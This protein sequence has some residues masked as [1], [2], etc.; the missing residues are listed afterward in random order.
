MAKEEGLLKRIVHKWQKA[1][2]RRPS[3][4]KNSFC[5]YKSHYQNSTKPEEEKAM[6]EYEFVA[7][8]EDGWESIEVSAAKIR[9][10]LIAKI[11]EKLQI[12][13]NT[14]F[15]VNLQK[16]PYSLEDFGVLLLEGLD[17]DIKA[18]LPQVSTDLWN[19]INIEPFANPG[20]WNI[21]EKVMHK[22]YSFA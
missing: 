13:S 5:D 14:T 4:G 2:K 22:K 21:V 20:V 12:D 19:K 1:I 17:K 16:V 6:N 10:D 18:K 7:Q 15:V 11:V 9:E 8:H 3:P